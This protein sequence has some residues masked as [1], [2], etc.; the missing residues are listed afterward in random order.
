ME[1]MILDESKMRPGDIIL[2]RSKNT[3]FSYVIRL[4]TWSKYSHAA[5]YTGNTTI[6][7]AIKSGV[8]TKNIVRWSEGLNGHCQVLRCNILGDASVVISVSNSFHGTRYGYFDAII[9]GLSAWS[10]IVFPIKASESHMFCSRL[11]A[12]S[13]HLAGVDL[14]DIAPQKVRPKDLYNS[15][16]LE[17]VNIPFIKQPE[18]D[19]TDYSLLFENSVSSL[20][21]AFI[22]ILKSH[23]V[24]TKKLIGINSILYIIC[25]SKN[26]SLD[27]DIA[28]ELLNSDYYTLRFKEKEENKKY[29]DSHY[30]LNNHF[31]YPR[32]CEKIF[33]QLI[34]IHKEKIIN[35][36]GEL[37]AMEEKINFKGKTYDAFTKMYAE[38]SDNSKQAKVS[39]D[40]GLCYLLAN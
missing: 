36:N 34:A 4:F 9:S 22:N 27:N 12:D 38:L 28:E 6:C 19:K 13:Y 18:L 25:D 1:K 26:D 7:E 14:C 21:K 23:S 11:V 2:T 39:F 37:R 33:E 16:Y 8:H 10:F 29:W 32:E 35:Y 24:K 20:S 5:I 40:T 31:E 15:K 17:K 30:Y 3:F